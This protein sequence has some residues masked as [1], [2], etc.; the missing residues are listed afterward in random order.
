M[1]SHY[2]STGSSPSDFA[3]AE[4]GTDYAW[5]TSISPGLELPIDEYRV[6]RGR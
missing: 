2:Y 6:R 3:V 5:F 1:T 4:V